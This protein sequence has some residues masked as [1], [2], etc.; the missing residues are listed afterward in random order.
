MKDSCRD[1]H[2]N[3][4]KSWQQPDKFNINN[5]E[6]QQHARLSDICTMFAPHQVTRYIFIEIKPQQTPFIAVE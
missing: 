6:L 5:S 4:Y 3:W 2:T 1:V